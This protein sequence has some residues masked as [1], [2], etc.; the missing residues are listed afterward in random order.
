MTWKK[1]T[2]AIHELFEKKKNY[3][4]VQNIKQ[5]TKRKRVFEKKIIMLLK[6]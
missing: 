5:K 2:T 3:S 4:S 6:S 1:T